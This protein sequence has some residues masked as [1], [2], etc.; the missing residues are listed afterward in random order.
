MAAM[1]HPRRGDPCRDG[2]PSGIRPDLFGL[3]VLSPAV[4]EFQGLLIIDSFSTLRYGSGRQSDFTSGY[5]SCEGDS[6][7]S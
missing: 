2:S 7:S 1:R 5:F 6:L 3:S 4:D